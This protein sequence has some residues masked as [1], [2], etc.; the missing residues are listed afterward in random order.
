MTG[1]RRTPT[2]QLVTAAV[3]AAALCLAA[4]APGR[5]ASTLA[6]GCSPLLAHVRSFHG[7]VSD[8][9]DGSASAPDP[10][11]G[12]NET[13][14]LGRQ[15]N[16]TFA[17]RYIG[18]AIVNQRAF[19]GGPTGGSVG[20]DD[21]YDHTG[22]GA[23]GTLQG[24]P[25]VLAASA[26]LVLRPRVCRYQVEMSFLGNGSFAG[27]QTIAPPT[28]YSGFAY[29]PLR[30][31]PA[32]LHLAGSASIEAYRQ[33]C[34]KGSASNRF[35]PP[36]VQGCYQFDGGWSNDYAILEQCN[37]PYGG[38]CGPQ[39]APEGTATVTWSLTPGTTKKKGP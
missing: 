28:Q 18:G 27:D 16:L 32:S 20:V 37:A 8:T 24:S 30:P 13:V 4:A 34:S 19:A 23:H 36:D 14:Q 10:G 5:A 7:K 38:S 22:T 2:L 33:G 29:T 6:R 1:I 12:G 39:D 17:L 21:S 9:F 25:R 31:I 15:A 11:Q 3:S 35:A 26:L